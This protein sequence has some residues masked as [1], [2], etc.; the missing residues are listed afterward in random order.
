MEPEWISC[1]RLDL[2]ASVHL[3]CYAVRY[4]ECFVGLR[5]VQ[6]KK[7]VGANSGGLKHAVQNSHRP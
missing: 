3:G 6:V 1:S 7:G 5:A 2:L 4:A